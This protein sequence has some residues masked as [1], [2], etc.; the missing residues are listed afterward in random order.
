MPTPMDSI[1]CGT[2]ATHHEGIH[3]VIGNFRG[4][5]RDYG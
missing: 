1:K 3:H 5:G 4:Q 2:A